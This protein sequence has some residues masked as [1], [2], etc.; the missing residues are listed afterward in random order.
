[1]K[2][3]KQSFNLTYD[4]NVSF[5]Q[6][7]H[8]VK[9]EPCVCTWLF[10]LRL[11]LLEKPVLC[12]YCSWA[13][14]ASSTGFCLEIHTIESGWGG[15]GGPFRRM[16][17]LMPFPAKGIR[18]GTSPGLWRETRS[19]PT[20]PRRGSRTPWRC[21]PGGGRR[22]GEGFGVG[23]P[24]LRRTVGGAEPADHPWPTRESRAEQCRPICTP[25]VRSK[26]IPCTLWYPAESAP[27]AGRCVAWDFP[28]GHWLP[29]EAPEA[30]PPLQVTWPGDQLPAI[31]PYITDVSFLATQRIVVTYCDAAER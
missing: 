3:V 17:P 15:G 19:A 11:H 27:W 29:S 25:P 1:M 23:R 13:D 26:T 28:F 10:P 2:K 14:P 9:R 4:I 16:P 24:Q 6:E 30:P 8:K 21:A 12:F 31:N 22:R 20:S 7:V 5:S 18:V